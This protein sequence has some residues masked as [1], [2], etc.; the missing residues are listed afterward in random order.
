MTYRSGTI[1]SGTHHRCASSSASEEND[2]QYDEVCEHCER[3][4]TIDTPIM[5]HKYDN[6]TEG[7]GTTQEYLLCTECYDSEGIAVARWQVDCNFDNIDQTIDMMGED[8][9]EFCL[10]VASAVA[11]TRDRAATKMFPTQTCAEL[12]A[13]CTDQSLPVSGKK[14]ELKRRLFKAALAD[15]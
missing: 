11:A 8:Q 9:V 3:V 10:D 5:V 15:S 14:V 1:S 4:L 12:K 6:G 2:E 7:D 13:L